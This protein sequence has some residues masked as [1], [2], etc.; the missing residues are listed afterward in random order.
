MFIAFLILALFY[1]W[2]VGA[3]DLQV[4]EHR[5]LTHRNNKH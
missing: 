4:A 2:R 5:Q 3:L 1:L